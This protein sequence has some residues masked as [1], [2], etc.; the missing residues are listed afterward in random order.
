MKL[1][2][3]TLRGFAASMQLDP[4]DLVLRIGSQIPFTATRANDHGYILDHQQVA[5]L[6][7]VRVMYLI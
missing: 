7:Y 5:A 2:T 4:L 3:A 6:P 1:A